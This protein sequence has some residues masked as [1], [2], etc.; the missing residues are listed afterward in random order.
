MTAAAASDVGVK[1]PI[2]AAE[3]DYLMDLSIGTPPHPY[4][5][6]LD[7]GSDLIWT[8]CNPFDECF[9]QT[10]PVFEP[11][12]S[13]SYSDVSC[14]SDFC[15]ELPLSTCSGSRCLYLYRYGRGS[16]EGVMATETFQFGKVSIPKLGFG[17]GYK[18]SESFSGA[19][20]FGRGELSLISQLHAPGFSYCLTSFDSKQPSILSIGTVTTSAITTPLIKNK[21]LPS[22][23][24]L[25]LVGISV[26][27]TR[28]PIEKLAFKIRPDGTGGTV[29]D[30]GTT[31]TFLDPTAFDQVKK[32]VIR[33]MG[34][35][36]RHYEG[37]EVCFYLTPAEL[38][39]KVK[40]MVFH[41]DG[42]DLELPPENFFIYS[43]DSEVGCLAMANSVFEFSIIG[44]IQ[45]QNMLVVYDLDKETLSFK[46][47]QCDHY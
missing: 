24:Y 14:S 16:T 6:I 22:F 36:S 30:S 5:V 15:K 21:F 13:S 18:N 44:N 38:P 32:E 45:Q 4:S 25:S 10:F 20:G 9:K 39:I 43:D 2:H 11:K 1:T 31:I 27:E 37:F 34:K 40:K 7:T 12:M 47:T 26:G 28:L 23:Y 35:T 17:C 19:V 3:G 8:Q 29:I 41:F 33:Q 42:G 46:H